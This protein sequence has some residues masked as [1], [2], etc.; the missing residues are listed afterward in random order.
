VLRF[1]SG[2]GVA[3]FVLEVEVLEETYAG[4]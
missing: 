4:N 1:R 3:R 2:E